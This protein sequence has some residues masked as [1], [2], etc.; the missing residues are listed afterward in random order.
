M[1]TNK[2]DH[3]FPISDLSE[4]GLTKREYFAAIAMQG[5]LPSDNV[6]LEFAANAAVK[7]ADL[8]IAELNKTEK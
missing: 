1:Q 6:S 5:L 3:V 4:F 8:L 2:D 7:C